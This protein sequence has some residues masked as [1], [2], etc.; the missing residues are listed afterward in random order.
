MNGA[1]P[2]ATQFA[3]FVLSAAGQRI[4]TSFGFAPGKEK[5]ETP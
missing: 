3:Q 1:G 2:Q 5:G 4:L